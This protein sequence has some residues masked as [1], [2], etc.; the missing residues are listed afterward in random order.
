[1]RGQRARDQR[2]T[3]SSRERPETLA[4]SP[5][6]CR[7]DPH[8]AAGRRDIEPVIVSSTSRN[9]A[10]PDRA[11]PRARIG[12]PEIVPHHDLRCRSRLRSR[13]FH[14]RSST[15][16]KVARGQRPARSRGA[17]CAAPRPSVAIGSTD[18]HAI[19]AVATDAIA[20]SRAVGERDRARHARGR[21]P[22]RG[23]HQRS[24]AGARDLTP[25]RRP[26]HR[27][28][29]TSRGAISTASGAV[30]RSGMLGRSRSA[31]VRFGPARSSP[32]RGAAARGSSSNQR[33][34]TRPR[35]ARAARAPAGIVELGS[36][37][38]ARKYAAS[39]GSR[40]RGDRSCEE[41]GREHRRDRR[42]SRPARDRQRGRA[43][44]VARRSGGRADGLDQRGRIACRSARC[45]RHVPAAGPDSR[46]RG[47]PRGADAGDPC[48]EALRDGALSSGVISFATAPRAATCGST[49]T[50]I[51]SS[52]RRPPSPR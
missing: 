43:R 49:S 27:A 21:R 39:P 19:S 33:S 11:A 20:P 41:R 32:A 6:T 5:A 48:R 4:R 1:V 18:L 45:C 28:E 3:T 9:R 51:T 29:P 13:H 38:T 14:D 40:T 25:A 2:L 37:E 36:R 15:R 46:A 34:P 17:P 23:M 47:S 7:P 16:P 24:A 12:E 31:S 42:P 22:R 10:R 26:P 50:R 35:P 30:P 8:A 52:A 44:A